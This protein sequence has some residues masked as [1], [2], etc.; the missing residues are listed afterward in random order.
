MMKV[1]SV[2]NAISQRIFFSPKML[3]NVVALDSVLQ[4]QS[5]PPPI[6][7]LFVGG[8]SPPLLNTCGV[9]S[10]KRL[11]YKKLFINVLCNWI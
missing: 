9:P 8:F 1:K 5:P 11:V 10:Q 6:F 3:V 2:I 4:P 7:V